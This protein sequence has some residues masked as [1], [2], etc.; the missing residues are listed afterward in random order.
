MGNHERYTLGIDVGGTKILT[1]L[2]D[3]SFR[4][5]AE[6]KEKTRPDKGVDHFLKTIANAVRSVLKEAGVDRKK[7]LAAGVGCP[8]FIHDGRG[9]V[10]ASPNIPFLKSFPLAGNLQEELNV[11]VVIGNDVQTGLYGEHQFGAAKGYAN[12]AGIFMG[13]GIGGALILNN[14]LYRGSTGSAG[15]IGHV[16]YDP[17]GPRCGCGRQGCFEAFAGRLAIAAEAA[18]TVARLKAPHLAEKSGT[19]LR[20]IKSGAIAKAIEAGDRAIEQIIREKG[21][22]VGS[23][24]ANLVNFVNPDLIVLGGGVVEAMPS[25][26]AREA[27]RVMREEAIG[28]SA[29]HVRVSVAK[30][31]DYSVVMGAAKRALDR[32]SEKRSDERRKK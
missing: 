19:D 14:Q 27:E 25:L 29:R 2:L 7:I 17:G 13:T 20:E 28:P 4:I 16:V 22:I 23:M 6:Y 30:L 1:A 9:T 5:V 24:M 32:F 15:E 3:P 11:P 18:I 26:I 8:G 10:L 31:G 12:V 21:R